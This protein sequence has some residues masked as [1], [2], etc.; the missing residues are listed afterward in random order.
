MSGYKFIVAI[1]LTVRQKSPPSVGADPPT[2]Y[3]AIIKMNVPVFMCSLARWETISTENSASKLILDSCA[4]S[5]L[6]AAFRQQ[7]N[8][9]GYVDTLLGS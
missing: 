4:P 5:A 6:P 3:V 2:Q 9:F 8:C 1:D 7:L